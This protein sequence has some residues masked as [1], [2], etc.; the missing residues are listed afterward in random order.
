MKRATPRLC[1]LLTAGLVA[2]AVG[3]TPEASAFN[4]G[5][6]MNPGKWMGNKKRDN[7]DDLPPPGY[8][9][10]PP[11][12]G[13]GAA[14]GYGGYG[15][16]PGYGPEAGAPPGYGAPAPGGYGY[17]PEGGAPPGYG[18]YAAPA[19]VQQ[20][21]APAQAPTSTADEQRIRQ[22][23]QR[24]RQLESQ[25]RGPSP[26]GPGGMSGMSG[27]SGMPGS[28]PM[29]GMSGMSGGQY[30]MGQPVC[31]LKYSSANTARHSCTASLMLRVTNSRVRS[32]GRSM[33]GSRR[34]QY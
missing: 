24:I 15:P 27:M 34:R 19:P 29:Q 22:L 26:M 5:D 30:P 20:A 21:P 11:G 31:F 14:P 16:A 9:G 12:Y 13:Y 1:T 4:F 6:M 17:G 8:G 23:E 10:P 25:P 2:A 32:C 33:S 3:F 28:Q 7:Y 18:G